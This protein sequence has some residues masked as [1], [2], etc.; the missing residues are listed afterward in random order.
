MIMRSTFVLIAFMLAGFSTH[1]LAVQPGRSPV[2]VFILA[3]QSNMEGQGRVSEG[4]RATL[5]MLV[6]KDDAGTYQHLVDKDGNWVVR[7][8]VWI[9]YN[10]QNNPVKGGLTI[11]QGTNS[12]KFGPELQ[13]GHILGDLL[14]NQVL[15]IKTC[16]GGK[17]LAGDFRP[18][19]SGGQT[20]KYYKDMLSTVEDVLSHLD[21][22]F[23]NYKGQGYE[24]T[25]FFWWQG[26]N[27]ACLGQKAVNEYTDNLANLIRDVRAE[28]KV[29]DLAVVIATSGNGG[30]PP[31]INDGVFMRIHDDLVPA[32]RAVAKIPEFKTTVAIAETWDFWRGPKES[33][34]DA[35]HHW[36][37]NAE[38]YFQVGT[39]MGSSMMKLLGGVSS[40]APAQDR[41]PNL[42]FIMSD[43]HT[44]EA[45]ELK[46]VT[47]EQASQ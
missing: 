11:G 42:L 15:L 32:Q 18:P 38:S 28:W 37:D 41:R 30:N 10:R 33:P 36:N 14:E 43:E 19:S 13:I 34:A 1:V 39:A 25:G 44:A 2:K 16:W 5:E 21:S 4:S 35:G 47:P 8:D 17:S 9:Y 23:P 22:Y 31:T 29:P 27:D 46:E 6:K 7:D 26:W 24:I 12:E 20:G 40:K 45:I 3:G